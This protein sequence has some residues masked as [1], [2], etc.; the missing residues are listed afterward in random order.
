MD[1]VVLVHIVKCHADLDEPVE[2]L[3]LWELLVFLLVSL[4][5]V[6]QVADYAFY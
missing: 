6:R 5:V 1:N 4:D 3:S 2:N